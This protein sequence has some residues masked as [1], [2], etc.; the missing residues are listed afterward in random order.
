MDRRLLPRLLI[1]YVVLS[2]GAISS[3]Y[4]QNR[5]S[6]DPTRKVSNAS[7]LSQLV[8]ANVIAV[9][10]HEGRKAV[11]VKFTQGPCDWVTQP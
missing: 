6:S 10:Y 8:E 11:A 1:L 2:V 9:Q 5:T 4:G 3:I 7:R